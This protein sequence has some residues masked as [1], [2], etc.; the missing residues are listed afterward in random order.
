MTNGKSIASR[1][2][3]VQTKVSLGHENGTLNFAQSVIFSGFWFFNE[4]SKWK[5]SSEL[6]PK[7]LKFNLITIYNS[8]TKIEK[9]LQIT[10]RMINAINFAS[11]YVCISCPFHVIGLVAC[12]GI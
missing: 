6:G 12:C 2:T 5:K 4:K 1:V 7:F 10:L 11:I 8:L 3:K 9:S